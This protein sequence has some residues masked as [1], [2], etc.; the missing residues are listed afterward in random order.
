MVSPG[1]FKFKK[2]TQLINFFV[3]KE[4]GIHKDKLCSMIFLADRLHLRRYGRLITDD[5]YVATPKGPVPVNTA[6]LIESV[7]QEGQEPCL[8]G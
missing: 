5:T 2:A 1:P 6:K 8:S 4:P 7:I 3:R